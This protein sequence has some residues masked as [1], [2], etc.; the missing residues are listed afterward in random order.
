M[1]NLQ[2][3]LINMVESVHQNAKGLKVIQSKKTNFNQ[4]SIF[5]KSPFGHCPPP[6]NNIHAI[7]C[8]IQTDWKKSSRGNIEK[9]CILFKMNFYCPNVKLFLHFDN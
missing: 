7:K 1:H 9:I 6:S 2:C 3:L 4:F 8:Y 5:L